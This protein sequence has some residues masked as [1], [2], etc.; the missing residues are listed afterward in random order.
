MRSRSFSRRSREI[1]AAGSGTEAVADA[2][3]GGT[4]D[5]AF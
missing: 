5:P 1:S 2:D 4:A 3:F